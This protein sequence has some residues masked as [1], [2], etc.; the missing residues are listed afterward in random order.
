MQHIYL[1]LFRHWKPLLVFNVLVIAA[2]LFNMVTLDKSWTADAKMILPNPTSDLNLDLGPSGNVRDGEGLVFSQQVDTRQILTSIMTSNDAV[3]YAWEAD[4]E[5]QEYDRLDIYKELFEVEA[6]DASTIL[7]LKA[8][9]SSPAI[10][11]ERLKLFIEAFQKRLDELRLDDAARRARYVERELAEVRLNLEQ[12]SRELIRFQQRTALV[13]PQVQSAELV[14]AIN[15]LG[16]IQTEVAAQLSD[17]EARA[18]N[19]TSRLQQTPEQ[20][21]V[22]LQLAEDPA[23]QEL[24]TQLA[25]ITAELTSARSLYTGNHPQIRQLIAEQESLVRQQGNYI[26]E[27]AG[28]VITFRETTGENYASLIEQLVV[29]ETNIRGL[30]NRDIILRQK[31]QEFIAQL[32][33]LP[34]YQAEFD[35]LQ[36]EYESIEGVYNGLIARL[37]AVRVNAFDTYP[38]V[39]SLDAPTARAK[40]SG[41]GRKPIAVGAILASLFG[42]AAV[43]LFLENRNPL[44]SSG[45]LQKLDLPFLGRVPVFNKLRL[46]IDHRLE[47]DLSFQNIAVA[48]SKMSLTDNR[49][50]ITSSALEE[51]KTTVTLGISIALGQMGF[52]VLLVDANPSSTKFPAWGRLPELEPLM[53]LEDSA[54]ARIQDNLDVLHMS[55]E[56][57]PSNWQIGQL[58][59]P[60][61]RT[62]KIFGKYDYLLVDSAYVNS[63]RM[64]NRLL[65]TIPN[66]VMVIRPGM[67]CRKPFNSALAQL[68]Q[69]QSLIIGIVMNAIGAEMSSSI[70]EKSKKVSLRL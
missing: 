18:A 41:P 39:R 8:E 16:F 4:P 47:T 35:R 28:E 12:A 11:E 14:S 57:S 53:E 25:L 38:A 67:S 32:E 29:A 50:V 13:N 49:I 59:G 36:R 40:P 2:A 31:L 33:I 58:L 1:M 30:Q 5:R 7:F 42:S 62:H 26:K 3:R 46:G 9:G 17:S 22:A 61:L 23:Y 63:S 45:D 27:V 52:R 37:G 64:A 34:E 43:V 66:T 51:G 10:A 60:D 65:A 21:V 69:S 44:L 20:A 6:A 48:L 70:G 54:I 56:S 24:R 19:L 55:Q 15:D 68:A